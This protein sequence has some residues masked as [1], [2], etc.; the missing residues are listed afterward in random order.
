LAIV[1]LLISCE[2]EIEVKLPPAE[3][4]IVI[5][6]FIEQGV[7]PLVFVTKS[8]GYFEPTDISTLQSIIVRDATV[9]MVANGQEIEMDQICVSQLP[10]E[11]LPIIS[12][13][14]GLSE[15][16]LL[17]FN[18][19]FYTTLNPAFFGK[20][21]TTYD[22]KVTHKGDE[23]TSSTLIPQPVKLDSLWF[24]IRNPEKMTGIVWYKFN[25][26]ANVYNAYR[27]Y[28]KRL[29]KDSNFAPVSGSVFE[30]RFFDGK[31]IEAY[32]FPGP[33]AGQEFRDLLAVEGDTVVVKFCAID[34]GVFRFIRDFTTS[35]SSNG[36]P[37]A[38]PSTI[39]TNI[40]GG[41]LGYW[42]GYGATYDT[43]VAKSN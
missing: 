29:G 27:I 32:F 37:F 35:V 21:G 38:A 34:E 15:T 43:L 17:L 33:R 19:C 3:D 13:L 39:Y 22:L 20:I 5:E 42:G 31:P 11:F 14:S 41:A 24:K 25:D 2:R 23:F 16:Q 18:Y 36:N 8:M 28:S 26:P 6:G 7:P 40:K 30:D 9:S 4:K 12:E 10:S 1:L